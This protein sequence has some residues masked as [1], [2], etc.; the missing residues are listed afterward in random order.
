[1]IAGLTDILNTS[2]DQVQA[3]DSRQDLGR[4]SFLTLFIAQ[5]EHQDPLNPVESQEFTAQL[6]Q[7]S[8][9]EQLYN[10]ND[11][12]DSIKVSQDENSR[13]Q[14]LNL[15]GK[16]IMAE[17][18]TL[19]LTQGNPAVGGFVLDGP[20]DCRAVI[21]DAD[22][23]PIREVALGVLAA[24]EHSFEWDGEDEAGI[25][26]QPGAYGFEVVAKDALGEN[27]PV[28]TMIK[29]QVSRINL[30]GVAPM[31]YVGDIPVSLSSVV[32]IKIPDDTQGPDGGG[33][34]ST[35]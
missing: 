21:L 20:A 24:G 14:V 28:A 10:L 19:A 35:P 7:F 9:L 2:S 27:V 26:Q 4:D 22:G 1:M 13:F 5:L 11:T 31:L 15:I 3:E 17:G 33:S 12:L 32:D 8:S 34:G 6:A 29:G 18:A 23:Y 30:E 16:D 25:S